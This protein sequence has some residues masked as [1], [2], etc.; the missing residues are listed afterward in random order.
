MGLALSGIAAF[1]AHA[2]FYMRTMRQ[3]VEESDITSGARGVEWLP[4]FGS[5]AQTA[6]GQFCVRTLARSRQ[7]RLILAFY[8]GIGLAFTVFLLQ[9]LAA[10]SQLPTKAGVN[11]WREANTPLLAASVVMMALAVVGL[12]MAFAFPLEPRA[13]WIFQAVGVRRGPEILAVTR[14][15]ILLLCVLPVWLVSAAVCLPTLA[16]GGKVRPIWR[17]SVSSGSFSSISLLWGFRKIPFTCSYLPGKSQVHMV[18]LGAVGLLWLLAQSLVF[19]QQAL[20]K[21]GAMAAVMALLGVA[22]IA[23][24]LQVRALAKSDERD[25]QFEEEPVPAVLELG[26]FRDGAVIGSCSDPPST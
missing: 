9:L 10:M 13:N 23:V 17:S 12:R 24:R 16:D 18:F 14:R 20:Q 11:V 19:E 21:R 8:M 15:V 5:A 7:H 22:A 2:F 1:M 25:L 4:S 6:I 3:I 26:L